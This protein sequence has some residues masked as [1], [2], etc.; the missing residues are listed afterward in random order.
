MQEFRPADVIDQDTRLAES[1][2]DGELDALDSLVS[3]YGRAV[4]AVVATASD[5][6]D[7]DRAPGVFAQ[8]WLDRASI[9]P[10]VDFAPWLGGLAAA[11]V[12]VPAS[13]LD[14]TWAVAMAID[15]VDADVRPVLRSHHLDGSELP[16]DADRHE[17]RLR[18]RLT[19]IG[20]EAGVIEALGNPA[21]WSD[22][23]DDLSEQVRSRLGPDDAGEANGGADRPAA[24]N[25]RPL[26]EPD[27]LDEPERPS[28]VTRSLRPVLLGLAGAVTV[29]FVAIV[30]LSAASGSP[31]PI[32]FTADLT[33]TGAILDVEG[34]ELTV[35]ERASGL[36]LELEA[37]TLP[38]RAGDQFY[39][40]VL[41]LQDGTRV[42]VGTFNEGFD[43]TLS[44][45]VALD[46]VD[47]FLVVTR[48]RNT[49][50]TEV[51]LKLDVPSSATSAS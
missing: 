33:P 30:A 40:G 8:A 50:A 19:Q 2:I 36:Q 24:V 27:T 12:G 11:A 51:V 3:R 1:L 16:A 22:P 18:R 13:E 35:T 21:A 42:A 10:G 9:E 31:D 20:D 17:L 46:R 26:G 41:V 23:D 44:G 6:T 38:R 34:G 32:A 15:A 28:R 45:G 25:E 29:L 47:E 48:E 39:E 7:S 14:E 5:A 37:P 4:E 43:V 49:D